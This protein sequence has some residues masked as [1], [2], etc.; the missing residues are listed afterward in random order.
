MA[1]Y[2]A[3]FFRDIAE[4]QAHGEISYVHAHEVASDKLTQFVSTTFKVRPKSGREATSTFEQGQGDVLLSYENEAILLDR[5]SGNIDYL[6]PPE[7]FNIENPVAVVN[8]SEN[9]EQ[10]EEFRDYLFSNDAE[11]IWASQGFRSGSDLFNQEG[12]TP[13]IDS[14]PA[15][16]Q[17]AFKPYAI[18]YSIDDL[19]EAF[20]KLAAEDP[21]LDKL[22]GLSKD[23]KPRSGWGSVDAFLFKR[24]QPGSG[25]TD[26]VITQIY[27]E[28]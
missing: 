6:N 18:S 4:Q 7:T 1:P 17:A 25:D 22:H 14:L 21:S 23:G 5:T 9:L 15:D 16:E 27:Q 20:A 3:W 28:V 19:A 24:A 10:A 13:I 8:T 11:K 12:E 26:G 2:A